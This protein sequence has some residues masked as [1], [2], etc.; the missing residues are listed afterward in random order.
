MPGMA[1]G[2]VA[3]LAESYFNNSQFAWVFA[4]TGTGTGIYVKALY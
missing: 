4:P 3:Y 2:Q 1:P